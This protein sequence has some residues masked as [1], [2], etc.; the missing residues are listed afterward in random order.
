MQW[1]E[2]EFGRQ[3]GRSLPQIAF[4]DP[5][6]LQWLWDDEVLKTREL[7]RQL[8][9]VLWRAQHILI[10]NNSD[11]SRRVRYH[12]DIRTGKR[13][14]RVEVVRAEEPHS[15]SSWSTDH[16]HFDL[17]YPAK[18]NGFD[19]AGTKLIVA[20]VKRRFFGEEK[21]RLS[22]ARVEAFFDD[23]ATFA[24]SPHFG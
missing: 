15:C 13:T 7:R 6:Y 17:L 1:T 20:A 19:K 11:G 4:D 18:I 10:P 22:R 24:K 3:K 21:A 23:V 8:A 14:T 2:L 16:E 12:S 5:G 9:H